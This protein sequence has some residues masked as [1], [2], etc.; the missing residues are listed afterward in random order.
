MGKKHVFSSLQLK[1]EGDEFF[2]EG[3]VSSTNPDLGNDIVSASCLNQMADII[4]SSSTSG[5]PIP[6]GY[7]HTEFLG[8][9][10]DLVPLGSLSKAWVDGDKLMVRGSL[11]STLASFKE[12]KSAI[13]RGE[14]NGLSIEYIPELTQDTFLGGEKHRLIDSLKKLVGVAVTARPMN[15]DAY[16]GFAAKN[17]NF[18]KLHSRVKLDGKN[19]EVVGMSEEDPKKEEGAEEVPEAG[20]A[21]DGGAEEKA[22]HTYKG[23]KK[24]EVEEKMVSIDAERLV[25]LESFEAKELE[26]AEE[27]RF[28]GMFDKYFKQ[29][30]SKFAPAGAPAL[31]GDKF[32]KRMPD[33]FEAWSQS[34]E[35]GNPDVMYKAAA[36]MVDFYEG[37]G[38]QFGTVSRTPKNL[39]FKMDRSGDDVYTSTASNKIQLKKL[40]LKAQIEHDTDRTTTGTEYFLSGPLLNDV[41]GPAIITH[42]NESH[43]F[44]GLLRKEDVGG[45]IGDTYGFRFKYGRGT[46]TANYDESATDDPAGVVIQRKKAHIPVVWYRAVGQVSGPTIEAARGQGGIGDAFATEV[47]DVTERLINAVNVDLFDSSSPADGM[48]R[49]GQAMSLRWL[50]DDGTTNTTLYSYTRTAGNFT[51][52][53]GV[54]TAKS[55]TP[56]PVKND[57]RTMWATVMENGASKPDL[58][59][60]TSYTQLRKIMNLLDDQQRFMN[61]TTANA[62]FEGMPTF[63]GI[64]VHADKDCDDGFIYLL[65]ARH[66]FL[67]VQLPPTIE[68][69]S[70]T[71]DFRKFQVKTYYALVG[72]APN[73]NYLMTG[74]NTSAP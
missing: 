48:T 19:L 64:P 56:N 9:H 35:S 21:P 6:I 36:R 62:G 25:K 60:V 58:M 31:N 70:K 41:F 28:K 24:K 27:S 12:A 69:L 4:N 65:D 14:L 1:S 7:E 44:Y 3:V 49:G 13:E 10:P 73:H 68:E 74:F 46:E 16:M 52:L 38:V 71:G 30:A 20:S 57:L 32:G 51:T 55:N 23:K 42:L 66:T 11:N 72:T 67:A 59:Y 18:E 63:D 54:L 50:C 2:I 8:G 37:K 34:L 61:T 33:E 17:L 26:A 45:R 5:R 47:R 15:P 53:Q 40:E 22:L 39:F 29:E 43:T